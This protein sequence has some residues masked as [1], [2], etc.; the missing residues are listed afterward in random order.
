MRVIGV[1]SIVVAMLVVG[2]AGSSSRPPRSGFEDVPLPKGLAF[3]AD[4]STVIESP[5]VKAGH[6]VYRGRL[7]P[8]SLRV[9]MHQTLVANGWRHI[10]TSTASGRGATQA[11][12]KAGNALQ[13]Q[14]YE[15]FWYTYLALDTSRRLGAGQFTAGRVEE[16]PGVSGAKPDSHEQRGAEIGESAPREPATASGQPSATAAV[17]ASGAKSTWDT[18]KEGTLSLGRSVR[19]F[20][21]GLLPN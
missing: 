3:D 14:I 16:G 19:D 13:V 21:I 1:L 8:E 17:P 2:C 9:A 5:G 20:F 11:Y 6:L 10:N 7:E 4:Q 12:E 18:V 15:G